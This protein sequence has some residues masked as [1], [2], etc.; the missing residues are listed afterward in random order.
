MAKAKT[1]YICSNCGANFASWSGKCSNCNEWNT[2]EQVLD[3]SSGS[4]AQ[5]AVESGKPLLATNML[6]HTKKFPL[7]VFYL[8]PKT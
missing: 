6:Q 1:K 3:V 5:Q 2:L 8:A 4:K 7:N